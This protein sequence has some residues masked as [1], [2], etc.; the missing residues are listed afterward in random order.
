MDSGSVLDSSSGL[1]RVFG[2][3]GESAGGLSSLVVGT[4]ADMLVER[5][6]DLDGLDMDSGSGLVSGSGLDGG[7]GGCWQS[8]NSS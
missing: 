7:T 2:M 5:G 8:V 4:T 6:S 3:E 1:D